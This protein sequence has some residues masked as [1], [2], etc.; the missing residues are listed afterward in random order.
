MKKLTPLFL[1]GICLACGNPTDQSNQEEFNFTYRM[2]TVMVDSG[3]E[4]LFLQSGLSHST[5]SV[6]QKKLYNFSPK[7][8]LEIIDLDTLSLLKKI[9]TDKEGD[10]GT[11]WPYAIQLDQKGNLIFY[12]LMEVRIFPPDLNSMK[13]YSLS[14]DALTGL[15]PD[16]L[17]PFNPKITN[18]NLLYG[19]YETIEQVPQ[20][21]AIISLED[22]NVKKIELNLAEKINPFTYSLFVQGRLSNKAYE[23]IHLE[24]A[25]NQLIIST[26]YFNEAIIFDL[27]SETVSTKTFHSELTQDQ[28]A[29]PSKTSAETINE[30]EILRKE[31]SKSVKFGPIYFDK[32]HQRFCRISRQYDK[33]RGDSLIFKNVL[34]VFDN[35]LN[36]LAETE[37]PIDPFSKK[38]FKD[39]K[40][41]SYV[42]VEDELGFAVFIFDF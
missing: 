32:T 4:L 20:G 22:R 26:A 18:G 23:P 38:F 41:Y 17:A 28:T 25:N 19:I 16:K 24:L 35:E 33:E 5:L 40:L 9:V 15:K 34:T 13:K 37:L 14:E 3:E 39:G 21:L 10:L 36:Q 8:E 42:N 31:A 2:D 29:I 7:S 27:A 30:M 11:G 1:L 12:G 6:D